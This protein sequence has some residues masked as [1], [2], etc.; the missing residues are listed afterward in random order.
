MYKLIYTE[1]AK[2]NIDRLSG[3]KKRQL[4]QALERLILDPE[5]GKRLSGGLHGLYSYRSGDY[6]IIYRL[7]HNE[8]TVLVLA[9]GHRQ[10]VYE[11]L[12]RK[13][14]GLKGYSVNE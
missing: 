14:R 7:I 5:A 9:V 4:K 6:R 11:K 1:E 3:R 10:D 13:I 2:T 12:T 8:I